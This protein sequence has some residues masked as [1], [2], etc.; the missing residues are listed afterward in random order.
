M[1]LLFYLDNFIDIF[2]VNFSIDGIQ[3]IG[4]DFELIEAFLFILINSA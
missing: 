2:F 1:K 3:N 4:F